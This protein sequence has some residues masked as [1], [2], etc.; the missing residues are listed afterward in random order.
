[1]NNSL[2]R[3]WMDPVPRPA[4]VL[5][6]S[7]LAPFIAATLVLVAGAGEAEST[8]RLLLLGYGVAIL[9]FMGGVQWGLAMQ[10]A[11]ARDWLRYGTSVVPALLGWIAFVLPPIAQ[12]PLLA[13]A[14][15]L[16]LAYDLNAARRGETP[17]WYP[18]LRW[19]LTVVVTLCLVVVSTAG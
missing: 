5:G 13:A 1:M 2:W 9:S 17:A 8:W 18:N 12:F 4:L 19:P 6:L 15:V 11:D 16:L 7:G 10:R 14:F 3:A